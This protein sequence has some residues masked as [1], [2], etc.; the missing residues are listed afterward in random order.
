MNVKEL[1]SER[2]KLAEEWE[3]FRPDL[4]RAGERLKSAP[5]D[6]ALCDRYRT[7]ANHLQSLESDIMK[8]DLTLYALQ[9]GQ[10]PTDEL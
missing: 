6:E 4:Q 1:E 2:A 10:N 7:I 5:M 3:R 9:H 8:V